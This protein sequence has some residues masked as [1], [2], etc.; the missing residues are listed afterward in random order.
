LEEERVIVP[1][2]A[3]IVVR[4]FEDYIKGKSPR[5]IAGELNADN[6][7]G[8]SK[9]GWGSST[10]NGN[11]KR[12]TGILNNELYIGRMVWNKLRYLKDPSSGRRVSRLNPES[13]WVIA[14]LPELRIVPQELWD[15]VKS[16]QASLDRKPQLGVKRRPPNLLSFLLKHSC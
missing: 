6:I 15:K 13:E 8:P 1:E 14:D 12:G 4:I 2:E 10:I 3:G 7:A 9:V 5:K 11:R 16:Y